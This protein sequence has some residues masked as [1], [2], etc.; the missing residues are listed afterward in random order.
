MKS[1]RRTEVPTADDHERREGTGST[2]TLWF[3]IGLEY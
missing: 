3:V 2:L 1:A